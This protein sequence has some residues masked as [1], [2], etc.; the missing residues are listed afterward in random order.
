VLAL[1][2]APCLALYLGITWSSRQTRQTGGSD[3]AHSE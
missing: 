2:G 3:A 1:F